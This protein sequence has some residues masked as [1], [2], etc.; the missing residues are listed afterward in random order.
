MKCRLKIGRRTTTPANSSLMKW[1]TPSAPGLLVVSLIF[2]TTMILMAM[3][4]AMMMM[5]IMLQQVHALPAGFR[6]E[7]VT[8]RTGT[9]GFNFVPDGNGGSILLVCR[10]VGEVYALADA[11]SKSAMDNDLVRILN[12][13]DK[14]CSSGEQGIS[15]IVGHPDFG[16]SNRYVYLFYTWDKNGG[17]LVDHRFGAVNVVSRWTLTED[18]EMIDEEIL[19]LTSPLPTRVHN[20]GDMKFGH[21]NHLYITLGNGGMSNEFSNAQKP[22]TLLGSILRI[23]DSGGIPVDNPFT[24]QETDQRCHETGKTSSNEGR[25]QEIW[26][27]GF[28]NPF[29]FALNPNEKNKTIFWVS[30]VGGNTW[31][32]ISECGSDYSGGNYGYKDR[33]GPCESGSKTNCEPSDEFIDPIFWYEHNDDGDGAAVGGAFVPNGA[34]PRKYDDTY[35]FADF[36]FQKIFVLSEDG[37]D[38]CR[39]CLPPR[40]T[41]TSEEFQ[42]TRFYG[43]L[44]QLTFGPYENSQALYYSLW[45][46]MGKYTIRRIIYDGEVEREET[47][48]DDEDEDAPRYAN[49]SPQAFI[50]VSDDR[51]FRVG[52][53][54]TFDGTGS[55]DPDDDRLFFL[56]NFGDGNFSYTSKSSKSFDTS[57]IYSVSLTVTDASGES[58]TVTLQVGI[59]SPPIPS[60][61]SPT[62]GD[63]FSVGDVFILIGF[64][65][66]ADGNKL[67]DDSM[68]WEVQQHHNTH[69]HPFLDPVAGN[70]IALSPAPPPE[71][72]D[73]SKNSFL[74]VILTITDSDGLWATVSRD[75]MPKKKTLY[76]SSSPPGQTL[77]LDGFRMETPSNGEPAKVVTWI[78]HNL[79][80]EI[81]SDDDDDDNDQAEELTFAGWTS[82]LQTLSDDKRTTINVKEDMIDLRAV[83]RSRD[84]SS[85]LEGSSDLCETD[86]DCCSNICILRV[87]Q[88]NSIQNNLRGNSDLTM[89]YRDDDHSPVTPRVDSEGDTKGDAGGRM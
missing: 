32:E 11:G 1:G 87:C 15:Q 88:S 23:T 8:L 81:D 65:T 46:P 51:V 30:D 49:R 9:T 76:F 83:F 2:Q 56:W 6:D 82:G 60:I 66:D 71:D 47:V 13:K 63:L 18:L 54:I 59:G 85:C 4:A 24:T 22:N 80:V 14:V 48:G 16:I 79:I 21:D 33:E 73:A 67:D 75:I 61:V 55:F 57:G 28:R 50:Q 70:N 35:L 40:P 74:R 12:I 78:N 44:V 38:P 26:A 43:Q 20:A 45:A 25:C 36:I 84:R 34:W 19:L 53:R 31:E 41:L 27:I 5:M 37:S 29:R 42:D 39:A 52:E 89:A 68:V 62:R 3:I 10:K 58:D 7:G 69:Y 86:G 64:A 17:C 77:I 72:F